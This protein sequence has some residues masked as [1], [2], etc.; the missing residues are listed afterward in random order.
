[1]FPENSVLHHIQYVQ[2][3]LKWRGSEAHWLELELL[4]GWLAYVG[5]N[6]EENGTAHLQENSGFQTRNFV[7]N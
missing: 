1:M 2:I 7:A 6:V 5:G 4:G 3:L